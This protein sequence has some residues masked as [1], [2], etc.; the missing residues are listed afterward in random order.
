MNRLRREE[1]KMRK[2]LKIAESARRATLLCAIILSVFGYAQAQSTPSGNVQPVATP[3]PTPKIKP[4]LEHEF[5]A[6]ILRDQRAIWTSPFHMGREDMKWFVP[7]TLATGTLL[8]TDIRTGRA[9]DDNNRTRLRI[10]RDIS[11]GGS[12]YSTGGIAAGFYLVGRATQNSR[13]RETGL[14]GM[15]ALIDS[16]IVVEVLKAA[17]QRPRPR[18]D[19]GSGEFFVSGKSFPSGHAISAW[20]LATVIAHEY[21]RHRP[22]VQIAAYGLATAVAISRYTGRNHFLGDVLVGSALGYGIGRYVYFKHHDT[23]LDADGGNSRTGAHSKLIPLIA[24][25]FSRAERT[26]AIALRWDF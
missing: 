2:P 15:E 22:A 16:S 12:F 9:L 5:F 10:S 1:I 6:N 7:L 21:G 11:W 13:A 14:L 24:P 25:Q 3:S 26:Y 20:S 19:N 17:T 4:S 8:T 23:S 18:F